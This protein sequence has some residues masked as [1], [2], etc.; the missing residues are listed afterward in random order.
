MK[1][2]IGGGYKRY[3][4]FLNIDYDKNANPD[5][6][7]DLEKD[8]LPFDDSTVEEVKAHHILEHLG[9]G[10]FHCM[11]EIYRVCEDGAIVDI[12]VPHHR[13]EYFL[14]DP[15]HKRPITPD[16][17]QLF[18]KKHNNYCIS[19]EDGS[20]KLGNYFDVDFEVLWVDY[21]YNPNYL[22]LIEE[23]KIDQ[24]KKRILEQVLSECNNV[25]IETKV[26]LVVVK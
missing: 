14:N 7:L 5:Y 26:K 12:V 25:I 2:N 18:S 17:L 13:H 19:I 11:K 9:D 15:T 16:G 10:F 20:S 1:I 3:P 21:N 22:P 4:D 8:I 24:N 6:V 23:A